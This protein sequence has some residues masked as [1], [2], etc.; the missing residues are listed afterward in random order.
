MDTKAIRREINDIDPNI[1]RFNRVCTSMVR[2]MKRV[3]RSRKR[4]RGEK[5]GDK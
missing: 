1:S 3:N 2:S 5:R 4:L